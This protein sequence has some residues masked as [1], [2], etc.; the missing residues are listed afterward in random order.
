M[1][2]EGKTECFF[3]RMMTELLNGH[4]LVAPLNHLKQIYHLQIVKN[5]AIQLCNI[6]ILL[7][8]PCSLTNL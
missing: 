1:Q 4:H 8:N 2:T 5:N 6:Y 7:N 3:D